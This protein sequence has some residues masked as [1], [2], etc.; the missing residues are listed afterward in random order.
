MIERGSVVIRDG[1]IS[2]V[3]AN[4]AVPPDARL[5]DGTGL[6]IYP[7]LIDANTNLG[8][9]EP[10]PQPSPA[11]PQAGGFLATLLRPPSTAPTTNSTQPLGLQPEILAEDLI[12]PGGDAMEAER[13]AGIT[14]ALSVPRGGIWIGQSALVN[15]AGE[16]PQQMILRSPVAMHVGFTPL[17]GVYPSSLMGVFSTL[18]QMLLDAVRYREAERVYANCRALSL[19]RWP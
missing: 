7:G 4:I 13:T 19:H 14:T 16:T 2:R 17:R 6:T 11:G 10:S 15:L 1:L 5:I 3:G 12:K 8:I 9:P 18:R